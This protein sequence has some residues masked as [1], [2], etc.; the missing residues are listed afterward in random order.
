[1]LWDE[2]VDNLV[3]FEVTDEAFVS[4]STARKVS[5]GFAAIGRHSSRRKA[6]F[7]LRVPAGT[8]GVTPYNFTGEQAG[9]DYEN[10]LILPRGRGF[11]LPRSSISG[12][13]RLFYA[14]ICPPGGKRKLQ[15]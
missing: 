14:T 15:V 3:G 5:E 8:N 13:Y 12:E 7:H 10:E 2:P 11:S 9:N 4:T 1:M 6:L